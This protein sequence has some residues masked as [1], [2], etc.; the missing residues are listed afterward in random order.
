MSKNLDLEN[1]RFEF[2]ETRIKEDR[3]SLNYC[4]HTRQ[5]NAIFSSVQTMLL[6]VGSSSQQLA[7]DSIVIVAVFNRRFGS[8]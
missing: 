4:K 6:N 5:M 2:Q 8:T 1:S 3:K 7:A